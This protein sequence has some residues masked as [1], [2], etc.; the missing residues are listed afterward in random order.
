MLIKN[1][2]SNNLLNNFGWRTKRKIVIIDSD[3]WGGIRMPSKSVYEK[4]LTYGIPVNECPY[5][6]NDSLASE[7]DLNSL[8]EVLLHFKDQSGNHPVITANCVLANPDFKKIKESNFNE[9]HYELF[10]ETLKNYP[11]H[12]GSFKLWKKGIEENIFIPQLH[13]REHLNIKRWMSFLKSGSKETIDTFNLK[14]FGISTNIT[15]E[16]RESY[17]AAFDSCNLEEVEEHKNIVKEAQYLFNKTF[18]FTSKSFVSPN[19]IWSPALESTLSDIGIKY[20]QGAR[21]Q[22][23][24][25]SGT[26]SRKIIRHYTGEYNLYS[27]LYLVR[28]CSFE[29]FEEK[30]MD[31]V[32]HCIQDIKNAF[33]WGKP[34]IICSHRA[35]YIGFINQSN[36]D[37]NLRLLRDLLSKVLKNWPEVEFLTSE[38]LGDIIIQNK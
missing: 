5:C 3:D 6:R 7:E 29:P 8:F 21:V 33:F 17:L 22:R 1:I 12:P 10:T 38:K 34:A 11:N 14:L 18:G 2:L 20:I 9:Y 30:R 16:K 28:N 36:R 19:Y 32:N 4:L 35:N 15:S 24:P 31:Y 37:N 27:Q 25:K 26:T 13:G 23:L